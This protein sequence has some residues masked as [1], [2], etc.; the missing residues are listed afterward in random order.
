MCMYVC[1]CLPFASRFPAVSHNPRGCKKLNFRRH[2]H[3]RWPIGCD[4]SS[5]TFD[6]R[7]PGFSEFAAEYRRIVAGSFTDNSNLANL[8]KISAAPVYSIKM[9]GVYCGSTKQQPVHAN[10]RKTI[11][12]SPNL[13]QNGP[14]YCNLNKCIG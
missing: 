1:A 6:G 9:I 10:L 5:A 12:E 7:L 4:N 13:F 11:Y 14:P 2:T 3:T 8:D